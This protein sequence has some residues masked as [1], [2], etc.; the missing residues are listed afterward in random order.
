M[1]ALKQR[2]VLVAGVVLAL[3]LVAAVVAGI[4]A[5]RATATADARADAL[6][7]ATKRVPELLS[8]DAATLDDD[9][10]RARAQTTGSFA[11]DYGT[12]LDEVVKPNAAQRTISTTATVSAAGV[13]SGDPDRVVVLLFLTQ[14][15]TTGTKDSSVAG[16]RVE[17]TMAPAGDDWKIV[18][19]KPL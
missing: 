9:L 6:A 10:A 14:T 11:D 7:A 19:L 13:V 17:V 12:I 8:Y 15:T 2:A 16:S 5:H 1:S 18:G 4:G 3:A